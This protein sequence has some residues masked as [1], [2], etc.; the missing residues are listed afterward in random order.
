MI[1]SN[2]SNINWI[3]GSKNFPGQPHFQNIRTII[4]VVNRTEYEHKY[5][6]DTRLYISWAPLDIDR[7]CDCIRGYWGVESTH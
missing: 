6:F 4:K 7:L 3:T 5:T 2:V 1:S